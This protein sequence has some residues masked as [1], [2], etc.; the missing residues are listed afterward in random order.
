MMKI[1]HHKAPIFSEQN[2]SNHSVLIRRNFK[3]FPNGFA[4]IED[5]AKW[6]DKFCSTKIMP[7]TA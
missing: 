1:I 6:L 5:K 3:K 4:V 7:H 2:L